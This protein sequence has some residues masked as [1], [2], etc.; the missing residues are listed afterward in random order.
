MIAKF[1]NRIKFR[2]WMSAM[3]SDRLRLNRIANAAAHAN[4]RCLAL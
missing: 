4:F 1:I 2:A 3:G